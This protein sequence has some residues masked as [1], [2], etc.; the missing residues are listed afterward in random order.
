MFG[1]TGRSVIKQNPFVDTTSFERYLNRFGLKVN[2]ITRLSS[3][4]DSLSFQHSLSRKRVKVETLKQF[5]TLPQEQ[6]EEI[7]RAQQLY[8]QGVFEYGAGNYALAIEVTSSAVAIE[9]KT[10]GEEHPGYATLPEN[11]AK[12]SIFDSSSSAG[13][14]ILSCLKLRAVYSSSA[15]FA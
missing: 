2:S 7:V 4:L 8:Q 5:S 1:R 11:L 15:F 12:R 6:R 10:L 13:R 3:T 14:V 9:K